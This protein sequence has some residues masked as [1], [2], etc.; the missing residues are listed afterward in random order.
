MSQNTG[1]FTVSFRDAQMAAVGF[2]KEA[3][4]IGRL[5]T[6]EIVLD[7][8]AVSRVHAGI[9]FLDSKYFLINLSASNILSLNGRALRPQKTDVLAGGDFI[10]IG[11]F[12]IFVERSSE[13]LALTVERQ[14]VGEARKATS[15][16]ALGSVVP[17]SVN[18]E[19]AD[20]LKVFWEKR[21]RE[22]ED[23]GSRL[24]P[25]EKPQPGK[26]VIN[27]KPTL[28]L[29]QPWRLGLFLWAIL[30]I[31]ALGVIA[32]L[33][34]PETYAGKPLA[35]PHAANIEGST[36]ALTANGNSCTTCHA[37]NEYVETACIRCHQADQ[38]HVSNTKAHEAAGITCTICHLEHQGS[39]FQMRAAA[40]QG[41]ADCH[42]NDNPKSYNGKSV[43]TAHEG[44]FGYPVK[45]DKWVWS[46]LYNEIAETIPAVKAS[47]KDET[48]QARLS[49]QFHAVHVS[50]LNAPAGMT[51]DGSGRVS[52]SSCHKSFDPID[53]DTPRQT[54]G[55]CHNLPAD[56]N[57]PAT[58]V[59]GIQANCVSCHIQHPY[60]NNRWSEYLREEA[61]DHRK[62]V[63]NSQIKQ[64]NGK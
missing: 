39:D 15:L 26:A 63:V 5:K 19:V 45:D 61:R 59:N 58:F 41:C 56:S 42:S 2:D 13:E 6:C 21:T 17:E 55:V 44:S 54:C 18:P 3:I 28:D 50:R 24:R 14:S 27:W 10:Q 38:F 52:C 20:V 11:P 51:A 49:R 1:K 7:H 40:V 8:K 46:G 23:W 53:R 22:K 57:P 36:I 35:T 16:P 31:G 48:E 43:R 37:P 33:R 29:Q 30:I 64:L 60:G 32:F 12:V 25:T 62:N 34:Y 4:L 47:S 9:N